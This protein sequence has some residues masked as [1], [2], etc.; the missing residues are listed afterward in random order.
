MYIFEIVKVF[1]GQAGLVFELYKAETREQAPR[2][3]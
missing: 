2:G 1:G 3:P